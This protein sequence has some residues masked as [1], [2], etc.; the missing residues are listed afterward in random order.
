MT[1]ST[2]EIS[3]DIKSFTIL[4]PKPGRIE[5]I[6]VKKGDLVNEGQELIV[7]QTM[8]MQNSLFA[9]KNGKVKN[10]NCKV[11]DTVGEGEILIEIE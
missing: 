1:S 2:T 7:I 10:V 11:G 8:K 5:N 9:I 3:N 4:S 6:K